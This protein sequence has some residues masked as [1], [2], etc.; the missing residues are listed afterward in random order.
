[1]NR[2]LVEVELAFVLREPLVGPSVNAAD[3][4]R[5]TD[6]VLPCI[7]I[8]DTRQK[9]RGPTPLVDSI[10]DAAACGLVVLGGRPARL[11]DID[12][13]RVGASLSINGSVEE[14][15]VASAV[16]GNPINSVAWLANKL[17][18]YGVTAEAGHVDPLGLV[19]QGHPVPVGRHR[20]GAVRPARRSHVLRRVAPCASASPSATL[21]SA[22][23]PASS[24]TS[25]RASRAPGSTTCC[26]PSTSS[27]AT[28]TGPAGE[29]VHTVDVPYHEPFVLFGFLGAVTQRLELVT[30][31]LILPQR[32]TALVAKQAAELDLLTGGRLRL[33][34]G[35]GRNWMEYEALNEDFTN[36]GA[37]IEEQVERAAPAVDRELVTF[38]GPW[39]HLDRVGLNPM[40]VQRPIPIW[41][42]SFVGQ[43]VE[44]VIRRIGAPGRRLVPA[45]VA[46]RPGAGGRAA[47]GLRRR[48]RARPGP[49]R[50]RVRHRREGGRRSPT[51]WVERAE[52]FRALGATHLRVMTAGGGFTTPQ[53]HLDAALRWLE[54]S[55]KPGELT[56]FSPG[57]VT[58]RRTRDLP[59]MPWSLS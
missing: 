21:T 38:D 42:G 22:T 10:A 7:E 48:G 33:G 50:H 31:I 19:H 43:V 28:P 53:E 4:I 24:R 52:A 32:Q 30:S 55:V 3:V 26:R 18:E 6:F 20:R 9:G 27:A 59:G 16:M 35:V 49:H 8:V 12:I 25:P 45:D 51:R 36:R 57:S 15:G 40:P 34:V 14:S 54:P 41:M 29:K 37:R 17:H 11:T 2:P 47:A 56:R 46:G 39:H 58:R 1:M 44:K 13:R 23:I 5:A